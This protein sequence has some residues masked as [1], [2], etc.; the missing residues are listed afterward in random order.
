MF[1]RESRAHPRPGCPEGLAP[2]P[3]FEDKQTSQQTRVRIAANDH[4]DPVRA[5]LQAWDAQ[6]RRLPLEPPME[7]HIDPRSRVQMCKLAVPQPQRVAV[8][9]ARRPNAKTGK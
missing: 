6:D 2:R 1:G 8:P 9:E 4:F 3:V 5:P 7:T